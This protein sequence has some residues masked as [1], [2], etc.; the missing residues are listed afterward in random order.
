[1]ITLQRRIIGRRM[2]AIYQRPREVPI[3]ARRGPDLA[4]RAVGR[5]LS[6]RS[7]TIPAYRLTCTRLRSNRAFPAALAAMLIRR[8]WT[9]TRMVNC[10]AVPS[11][12]TMLA[13]S[14]GIFIQSQKS[15]MRIDSS[16]MI[17]STRMIDSSRTV[18]D[19]SMVLDDCGVL[20]MGWAGGRVAAAGTADW[21][22][23]GGAVSP[24]SANRAGRPSS[25]A[26]GGFHASGG[27]QNAR[28]YA[29]A[30]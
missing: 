29:P 15:S 23:G 2:A 16:R 4:L 5:M 3:F 13:H 8:Q 14:D 20:C 22:D 25:P 17:H 28:R 9:T 10:R 7:G 30:Q 18:P 11:S 6:C 24:S 26:A 27:Q 21:A 12:G 1:M 19:C